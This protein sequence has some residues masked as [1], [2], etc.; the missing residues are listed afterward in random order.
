MLVELC[1]MQYSKRPQIPHKT[2]KSIEDIILKIP[3]TVTIDATHSTD[4]KP[5]FDGSKIR[6][7]S[8]QLLLRIY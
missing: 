4:Q 8:Y 3:P 2:L 7:L 6:K 5:S 1:P